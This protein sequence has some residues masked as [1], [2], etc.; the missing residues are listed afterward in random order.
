MNLL[1]IKEDAITSKVVYCHTSTD[2]YWF[3]TYCGWADAWI[4]MLACDN[5]TYKTIVAATKKKWGL[6]VI[7]LLNKKCVGGFSQSGGLH[8]GNFNEIFYFQF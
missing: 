4:Y 7:P 5:S 8:W 6:P 3:N 1:L 2:Y